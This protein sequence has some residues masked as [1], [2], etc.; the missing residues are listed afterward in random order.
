METLGKAGGGHGTLT[1]FPSRPWPRSVPELRPERGAPPDTGAVRRSMTAILRRPR[2]DASRKTSP[3]HHLQP[4]Y[5]HVGLLPFHQQ[6]ETFSGDFV[7]VVVDEVH[8][9]R[10]ISGPISP[11]SSGGC[12]GSATF[13]RPP[14]VRSSL[15]TIANAAELRVASPG[16][17]FR[18]VETNGAP[19]RGGISSHQPEASATNV[20]A[21]LFI[22]ASRA[23]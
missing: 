2:G 10:G 23:D 6:W 3:C 9:Y 4:G 12:N 18:A 8:T 14:P 15:A 17:P 5:A 19:R 21:K 11:R 20:A 7:L 13:T 1:C 16:L 22:Q